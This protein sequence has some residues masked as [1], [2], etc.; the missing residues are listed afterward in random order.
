MPK[1]VIAEPTLPAPKIPRKMP[2][3][4]GSVQLETACTPLAKV[5][6]EAPTNT[7]PTYSPARPPEKLKPTAPAAATSIS[8]EN[9]RRAPHRSVRTPI[10]MRVTVPMRIGKVFK[11]AACDAGICSSRATS[12]I[13]GPNNVQTAKHN[14]NAAVLKLNADSALRTRQVRILRYRPP[15]RA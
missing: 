10:G 5:A 1:V 4:A 13:E 14:A 2:C 15:S 9:V 6:P 7:A 12:R 3:R 8:R 11:K